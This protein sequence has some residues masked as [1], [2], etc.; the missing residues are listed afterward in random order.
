M[1]LETANTGKTHEVNF[2]LTLVYET[3]EGKTKSILPLSV[4]VTV[5]PV[6]PPPFYATPAGLTLIT[7]TAFAVGIAVGILVRRKSGSNHALTTRG[8]NFF[9]R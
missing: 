5:V 1:Q 2:M 3:A 8:V 6:S 7:V 9:L 4:S